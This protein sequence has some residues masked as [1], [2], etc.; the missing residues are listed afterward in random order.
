MHEIFEFFNARNLDF[1]LETKGQKRK[2]YLGTKC[3][4]LPQ[5]REIQVDY[6]SNVSVDLNFWTNIGP[7][8]HCV[9]VTATPWK[10]VAI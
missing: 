3:F 4:E 1:D 7:L 9:F 10:M 6:F 2:K 8:T 5:K